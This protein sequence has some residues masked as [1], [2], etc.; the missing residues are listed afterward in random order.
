MPGV[1]YSVRAGGREIERL[2]VAPVKRA[3]NVTA[4]VYPT[5]DVLPTN[6]LKLYVEFS[7]AMMLGESRQRLRLLDA[8][9]A[10]VRNAFLALDAEM[11]DPERRRLTILFE[12]GRVKRGLKAHLESGTPLR[13]GA[14]YTVVIDREWP[15]AGGAPMTAGAWKR[16]TVGAA[17]RRMPSPAAW[18]IESPTAGTRAPMVVSFGEPMDYAVGLNAIRII[19]DRGNR[20]EGSAA[21]ASDEREWRFTPYAAWRGEPHTLVVDSRIEDLA[22]NNL[23]RPF[24]LDVRSAQPPSADAYRVRFTPSGAMLKPQR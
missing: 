1:V 7:A 12:P 5:A 3:P 22:G 16:F 18:R 6:Q 14:T 13:Q 2:E 11:W 17:D 21:L 8:R 9:G 24:D 19:D 10:E 20:L 4:R 23:V 15:D